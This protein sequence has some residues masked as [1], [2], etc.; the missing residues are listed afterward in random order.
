MARPVVLIN[1][2]EVPAADAAEF[3][4][5]WEKTRDYLEQN[6]AHL[7]TSLHQAV[8]PDSKFQFINIAHWRSAQEFTDA[9][10]SAGFQEAASDLRWPMHPALYTVI[11]T[12]DA[13]V[14]M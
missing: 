9:I 2:F 10:A 13:A 3:V 11:R 14:D 4:P 7:D 5:A 12:E 8:T 1:V 6:P